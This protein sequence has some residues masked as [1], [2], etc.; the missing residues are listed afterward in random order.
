VAHARPFYYYL[1]ILLGGFSPWSFFLPLAF[2]RVLWR[3]FRKVDERALF[4]CL[5][6]AVIFLFFSAAFFRCELETRNLYTAIVSGCVFVGWDSLARSFGE[7]DD[8]IA[9]SVLVF[10]PA[11]GGDFSPWVGLSF[12]RAP[13]HVEHEIWVGSEFDKLLWNLLGSNDCAV[14]PLADLSTL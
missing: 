12:S 14:L 3:P 13:D 2:V 7:P 9:K 5:W 6:F 1:P 8:E 10:F 4:L 11:S